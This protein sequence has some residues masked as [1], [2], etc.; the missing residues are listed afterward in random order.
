MGVNL[1][2]DDYIKMAT[3]MTSAFGNTVTLYAKIFE[4]LYKT[5]TFNEKAYYSRKEGEYFWQEKGAPK[6]IG[7]LLKTVGINGNTGQVDKAL[8][9]FEN[10]SKLK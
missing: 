2:A 7:H 5:V 3:T 4:D 1:G 8:E 10:A 6:V 9:G